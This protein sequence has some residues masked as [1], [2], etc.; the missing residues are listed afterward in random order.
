MSSS[1]TFIILLRAYQLLAHGRWLSPG[2]PAS[3]TT[4]TGRHDIAEILLNV[5]LNIKD[6]SIISNLSASIYLP[7]HSAAHDFI[8]FVL[9]IWSVMEDYSSVFDRIWVSSI[10]EKGLFF[11][12]KVLTPIYIYIYYDV[13]RQKH[14][15]SVYPVYIIKKD[16]ETA[17]AEVHGQEQKRSLD[18]FHAAKKDLLTFRLPRGEFLDIEAYLWRDLWTLKFVYGEFM[19]FEYYLKFQMTIQKKGNA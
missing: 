13:G 8:V 5:T 2:I 19:D 4:K 7:F 10:N 11:A 12:L 18:R 3:S 14:S 15:S 6:Q 17:M 9:N 1:K 16:F